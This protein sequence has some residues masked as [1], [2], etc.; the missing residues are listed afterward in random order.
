MHAG[1]ETS[2]PSNVTL[3]RRWRRR[4]DPDQLNG[5]RPLVFYADA[6]ELDV[7]HVHVFP[8]K[9]SIAVC[10]FTALGSVN[11]LLPLQLAREIGTG[12]LQLTAPNKQ[13]NR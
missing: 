2:M 10:F 7:D 9:D 3:R 8:S 1:G 5:I 11:V 6:N 12:L 13:P 4:P